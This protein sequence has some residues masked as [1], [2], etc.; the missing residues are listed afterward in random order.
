MHAGSASFLVLSLFTLSPLRVSA[1]QNA[2]N[3]PNRLITLDVAVA[4]K[5]GTPVPGLRQQ[6]FTLLDN[7]Q[8]QKILSFRAPQDAAASDVPAQVILVVD[9][10]NTSFRNVA[11]ERIQIDKFLSQNN[12]QLPLPVSIVFFTDKGASIGSA[13]SKDGK[14]LIAEL[15][16]TNAPLRFIGRSTGFYGA[17]DRVQLS[18][19]TIGEIASYEA[20]KPG[21]KLVV[22]ISP[23]WPLLSGPRE[24]L[25]SKT[26]QNIFNTIVGLSD[27]LRKA[28]ITLYSVDPLGTA[29]AG[30]LRT[31]YYES[32][33]K[34]VK[35]PNQVQIG[36]LGLQV[37]A[38]QSGGL[39][40]NSSNDVAGE[41]A[42]CVDDA[43]A[44]YV[45][46][47]ESQPADGPNDYHSLE[48]KVDRPKV[49]ARTRTGYYAQPEQ[50]PTR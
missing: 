41:I 27:A 34:G 16:D 18:L 25:S 47:F 26:Q 23:G 8:P 37:L 19:N 49:T 31:V 11:T 44:F 14:A 9:E 2:P 7:K 32:F 15:H 39:A 4:E 21:R 48:V 38:R 33:L 3:T 36:N 45:L 46:T 10:V 13:P 12:G 6:D 40:L 20:P 29:D 17:G 43:N 50:V 22:W 28:K 30:G 35:T 1:W 42:Q 24:D 5:S